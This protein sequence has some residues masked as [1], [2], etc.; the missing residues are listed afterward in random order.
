MDEAY[1]KVRFKGKGGLRDAPRRRELKTKGRGTYDGDKAPTIAT[2][3][4][5]SGRVRIH[6]D[7]YQIIGIGSK[8]LEY[9][10]HG[11]IKLDHYTIHPFN[12][13]WVL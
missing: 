3:R 6:K 9:S 10:F 11:I 7:A 5:G 1:V 12:E 13:A 8:P 2:V 4:R